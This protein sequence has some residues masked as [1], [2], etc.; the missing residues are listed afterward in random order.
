MTS[1][2]TESSARYELRPG[3]GG[4][5]SVILQ[6]RF[7]ADSTARVWR[8]LE[9]ELRRNSPKRMDVDASGIERCDGAGLALLHFLNMGGPCPD[10]VTTTIKGLRP[11]FNDLFKRFSEAD[12][13][14]N[15]PQPP[16]KVGTAE[17]V[18]R[19]TIQ[20]C[21]DWRD[22]LGFIGEAAAGI[23]GN[24]AQPKRMRWGEV[25]RIFERAGVN[26]LPIISL[27]S[28]L[29]G[30]IIAFEAAAPFQMFGAEIFIA[31]ML[32]II[33]AREM[34]GLVTAIILAG[35]SGSA[36]AAELG[37][38]KVNEEINALETM[39]LSPMRFLVVQR[40]VAGTLLTPLLTI[41][42]IGVSI[43]GG[44]LVMLAMG[45]PLITI[46]HQMAMTLHMRDIIIGVGK[47][48]IFGALIAG[49]G[50][51]KGLQ[52]QKGPSAVG[53][54][55]TAAVVSGILLIIITDAVVAVILFFLHL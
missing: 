3:S 12:Y 36:F 17:Q 53:E 13:Q 40:I 15:L 54:S 5:L 43:A 35:R 21:Q 28:L 25:W 10:G 49:V 32:G 6:G 52:T 42:A 20:A 39:G 22:K 30:L 19:A 55:A 1:T 41:Y 29:V 14:K 8:E 27:I 37:T 48:F 18:G 47:G 23:V 4:E 33:M 16:P 50:C 51:L 45:F 11:E 44:V 7:D 38:M 46:Y 24:L 34:A 2:A 26:A 31:N 9:A